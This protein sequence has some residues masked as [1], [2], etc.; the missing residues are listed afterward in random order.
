MKTF[1]VTLSK[2][3]REAVD[4]AAGAMKDFWEHPDECASAE[5]E[6]V[7]DALTSTADGYQIVAHRGVLEDLKYRLMMQ[8][9]DVV[10]EEEWGLRQGHIRAAEN[11]WY[12]I[13]G[14]A[15]A[16]GIDHIEA[17]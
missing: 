16:M 14:H 15:L 2:P 6:P 5:H 1:T 11:A 9:P 4:W 10:E 12:K 3:Q 8:L 13:E 17:K 7:K